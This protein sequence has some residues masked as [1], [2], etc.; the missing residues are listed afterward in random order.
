MRQFILW[1]VMMVACVATMMGQ[2]TTVTSTPPKIKTVNFEFMAGL[3]SSPV[4]GVDAKQLRTNFQDREAFNPDFSGSV[5]PKTSAY[6]GILVDYRFHEIVGIGTGMV[7]SPKGYW[8]FEKETDIDFRRRT[9]YTVDY[10]EFPL[11]L[12]V[13]AHPKVWFRA[14][15][16]FS[17][18]GI[19]KVRIIT[20]DG[21][22]SEKEKYRFGENGSPIAREFVP[23]LEAAV[24]FGNPSGFHGTFGVQYSGSLYVEQDVKPVMFRLGFGY[25]LT[26]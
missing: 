26:K 24:S 25:T 1:Q 14:G 19:T 21:N 20:E 5:L 17:F 22:N 13:Y 11:F 12:Q 10:F 4:V 7:Y 15:P 23:G 18:A 2:T 3:I 9:Y 8:V 16:V 6:V